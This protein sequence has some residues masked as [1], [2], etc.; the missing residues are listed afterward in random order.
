M[1]SHAIVC[2]VI[3]EPPIIATTFIVF[4]KKVSTTGDGSGFFS[5]RPNIAESDD[6]PSLKG[7]DMTPRNSMRV[8]KNYVRG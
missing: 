5:V 6:F 1:R 8:A 7:P 3:S 4:A 2:D